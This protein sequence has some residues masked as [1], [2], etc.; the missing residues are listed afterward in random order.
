M[1]SFERYLNGPVSMTEA[2]RVIAAHMAAIFG[3]DMTEHSIE[4]LKEALDSGK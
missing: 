3:I 4:Q 1:T 2:R